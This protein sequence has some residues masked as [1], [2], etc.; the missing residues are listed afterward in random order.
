VT[1]LSLA[2]AEAIVAGGQRRSVAL[3]VLY[4]ERCPLCRR[5]KRWLGDQPTLTSIGFV[6]A[7]SPEARA[8]FPDLD[9]RRTTHTLTVVASDGAVYEGERAWLVCGWALPSWQPVAEHL[10][11]GVRLRLVRFAT[12]LVDGYRHRVVGGGDCERCSIA[13]PA[14][15]RSP[16]RPATSSPGRLR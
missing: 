16:A 10:G 5:L 4:D 7:G 13:A 1:V 2:M 12:Q 3:T 11:T 9:H 15:A 14:P 8:R 6:A